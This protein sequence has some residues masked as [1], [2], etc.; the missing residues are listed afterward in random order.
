MRNSVTLLK[1]KFNFSFKSVTEFSVNLVES[2]IEFL[3]GNRKSAVHCF[4]RI[5]VRMK[6]A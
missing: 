1:E 2:D 5:K 4:R 6:T 3:H